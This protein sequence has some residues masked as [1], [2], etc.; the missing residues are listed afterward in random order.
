MSIK[1]LLTR[2]LS[3]LD[4]PFIIRSYSLTGLTSSTWYQNYAFGVAVAGYYPVAFR[5]ITFN[6]A[7]KN[8]YWHNFS[9]DGTIANIGVANT[10][11][12][13]TIASLNITIDV[14]YI[15]QD[16]LD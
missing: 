6:Q 8:A 3:K 2:I 5:Q 13:G 14:L 15:K 16:L 4:K 1:A 10:T 12:T 9:N 7:N 11:T